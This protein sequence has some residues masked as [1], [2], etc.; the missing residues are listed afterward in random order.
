MSCSYCNNVFAFAAYIKIPNSLID[1]RFP[2]K[3]RKNPH[4]RLSSDVDSRSS[5]INARAK[6]SK[7]KYARSSV[8]LSV[9][10]NNLMG[11]ANAN[12][13]NGS[14]TENEIHRGRFLLALVAMLYGTL[15]VS[16]RFVYEIPEVPPSAA[17]L[18]ATR[19]WL[20]FLCFLPPL[21]LNRIKPSN[22]AAA[23]STTDSITKLT[24]TPNDEDSMSTSTAIGPLFRSGIE[25]AMWNFLAQGLLTVGL[26]STGSG[27]AS[28]LT[29]TSVLFTPL[30][31]TLIGKAVIGRNVWFGCVV[32]LLGLVV[33]T[34]GGGGKASALSVLLSR[35][36]LFVLGGALSWSMYLFRISSLGPKYPDLALQGV[37]TGLVAVIYSFWWM[38]TVA[39]NNTAGTPAVVLSFSSLPS[40][41]TSSS[42][43]W[44]A[45]FFSAIGPGMIADVLQQKAQ[46]IISPSET[47]ILLSAEP[48]F[49]TALAVLLLGERVSF[50]EIVGGGLILIAAVIASASVSTPSDND[51]KGRN[52]K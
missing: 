16:L 2:H 33:L 41:M 48:I 45:L 21:L 26:V 37:K 40:W 8:S 28:F 30:I 13:Q 52:K 24:E 46:K 7:G 42:V 36:D 4:T 49:A 29:Q 9:A 12:S 47:N 38:A 6:H 51:G 18:S 3:D 11:N 23:T 35:G 22:N 32:A 50:L 34:I 14:N 25:L 15:N 39:L 10:E 5:S 17:A 1:D 27:R 20:A 31:S 43:V 19:G 44:I